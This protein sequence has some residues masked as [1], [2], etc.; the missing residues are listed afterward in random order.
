MCAILEPLVEHRDAIFPWRTPNGQRC[1]Q[2]T[3]LRVRFLPSFALTDRAASMS[4]AGL[5][6]GRA[7]ASNN[8][9][10]LVPVTMPRNSLVRYGRNAIP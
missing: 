1:W 5:I 2:S 8:Q 10:K 6:R 4:F 9:Q 7:L 3:I